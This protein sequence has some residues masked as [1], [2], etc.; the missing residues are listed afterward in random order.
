MIVTDFRPLSE[1]VVTIPESLVMV[2]E[3]GLARRVAILLIGGLPFPIF[4]EGKCPQYGSPWLNS[5]N[6]FD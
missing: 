5:K 2:P 4:L 1:P 3:S 6:C